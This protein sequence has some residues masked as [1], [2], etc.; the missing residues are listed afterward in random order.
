MRAQ[1]ARHHQL[2][3]PNV[4]NKIPLIVYYTSIQ[5]ERVCMMRARD[6]KLFRYE[7]N[8][9]QTVRVYTYK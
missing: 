9:N 1:P 4:P 2:P 7:R 5:L 6:S 3:L 8:N